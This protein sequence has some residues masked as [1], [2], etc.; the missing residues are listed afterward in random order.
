[1]R[2]LENPHS[3]TPRG[4]IDASMQEPSRWESDEELTTEGSGCHDPNQP[5]ILASLKV[6]H[7]VF[8]DV[9]WYGA[10]GTPRSGSCH[11][12]QLCP[13]SS[14]R[15]TETV[16][17]PKNERTDLPDTT[18]SKETHPEWGSFFTTW[19]NL[20]R[21]VAWNEDRGRGVPVVAYRVKIQHRVCEDVR[22]NPGLDQWV[23]DPAL[24]KAAA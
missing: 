13:E 2:D 12:R 23:K 18:R 17:E 24:P 8:P 9:M 22:S 16:E 21:L 1:M 11:K 19:P 7:H 20:Y 14:F 3:V 6:G 10:C 5:S 4:I 15:W